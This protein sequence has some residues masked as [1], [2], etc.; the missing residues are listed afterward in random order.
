MAHN[1]CLICAIAK[2]NKIP[3]SVASDP[4][5]P[6]PSHTISADPMVGITPL[7]RQGYGLCQC[8]KCV[9]TSKDHFFPSLSKADFQRLFKY[10]M[11]WYADY[12][13]TVR[14]FRCDM[15]AVLNSREVQDY[16]DSK[17][18]RVQNSA[19]YSHHQNTVERN[20]QTLSKATA[21]T[22]PDQ[23]HLPASF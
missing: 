15:E 13:W 11:N 2:K 5:P 16:L 8:F 10:V 21:T 23:P 3:I 20:I 1:P 9:F 17:H 12:G 19:P 18:I 6:C 22:M 4:R 7:T 14:I